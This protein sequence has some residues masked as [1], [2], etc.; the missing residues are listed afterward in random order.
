LDRGN[1][2][3]FVLHAEEPR[4]HAR[5][6]CR[7]HLKI[8]QIQDLAKKGGASIAAN[9]ISSSLGHYHEIHQ[10][11]S[12]LEHSDTLKN[13][14]LLSNGRIIKFLELIGSPSFET[15]LRRLRNKDIQRQLRK[16]LSISK[17]DIINIH[18]IH[19]SS[20]PLEL[21]KTALGF[22][23]VIWTLHDCWSFLG[24]YYPLHSIASTS[25][26]LSAMDTFWQSEQVKQSPHKLSAITPSAWM[27]SKASA[28]YW[29]ELLVETIHN[30]IPD[31]F[32]EYR[33]RNSCKLALGLDTHKPVVLCVAGNLKEERKGGPILQEI[34][35]A[36]LK[37]QVQFLFIGS[38]H[39]GFC[40]NPSI[41]SLE[42][43]EDEV[44]LKI[45]YN[46][47]DLLLHPAPIDNL[48]N[49]VA[50][51][52]SSGTPVLAFSTGG[53]PEMVV[54]GKSGWLVS[55][56]NAPSMIE[57]LE[58]V[59]TSKDYEN[60]RESTKELAQLLYD[61]YNVGNQYTKHYKTV[62]YGRK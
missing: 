48:P 18:N 61:S 31:S 38:G 15:I 54:P 12:D 33:D 13:K 25:Q 36:N 29:D 42:F 19:S 50:E 58:F 52:M 45:A 5:K 41:R 51:S 3:R 62:L 53:L 44:T 46:A 60:L 47:A 28:S 2:E 23:P 27:Q 14:I 7:N 43:V 56:I 40:N 55:E 1:L 35:S 20:W 9:R 49:T 34:I 39:I 4:L 37:H 11:S 59:L 26:T 32:F 57:K 17:P 24:T 21:I 8:C 22:A 30:P 16:I 6:G 10:I